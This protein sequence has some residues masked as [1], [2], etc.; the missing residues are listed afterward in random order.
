MRPRTKYILIGTLLFIA[1]AFCTVRIIESYQNPSRVA[2]MLNIPSP[3]KSI[4]VIECETGNITDVI[5]TCAIEIDPNEFPLLLAGHKYSE[6]PYSG[7][8]YSVG[9]SR[10]GPEFSVAEQYISYPPE[11]QHGGSVQVFTN[12]EKSR[13]IVDLYIE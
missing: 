7:T 3:P 8:S 12:R 11:F 2:Y 6:Y 13:A 1:V 5:I 9:V 4:H 10:L